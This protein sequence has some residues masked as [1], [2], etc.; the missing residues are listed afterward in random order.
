MAPVGQEETSVGISQTL[1]S[2]S[3]S[4]VGTLVCTPSTAMSEQCTA[5]HMFRQQAKAMRSLPGSSML[6]EVRV[7]ARP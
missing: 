1:G 7:Q 4:I 3:W 6:G 2:S 5:P